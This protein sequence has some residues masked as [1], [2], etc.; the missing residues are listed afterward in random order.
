MKSIGARYTMISLRIS[1]E[2]LAAYI[3]AANKAGHQRSKWIRL[4][5]NKACRQREGTPT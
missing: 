2:E 1:E 3:K 5:L 4:V